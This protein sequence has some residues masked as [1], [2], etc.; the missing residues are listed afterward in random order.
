MTQS[1]SPISKLDKL[2]SAANLATSFGLGAATVSGGIGVALYTFTEQP[3][4]AEVPPEVTAVVTNTTDTLPVLTGI[5]LTVFSAGLAPW[6]ART[7][8]SWL[9]SIMRG[10]I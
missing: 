4:M 8:L 10:S 7:T 5:C 2:E 9:S 3:A 6:A 1:T